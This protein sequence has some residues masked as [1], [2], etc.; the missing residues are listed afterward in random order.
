MDIQNKDKEERQQ[1]EHQQL[2]DQNTEHWFPI[3]Q[4]TVQEANT[5]I[6]TTRNAPQAFQ[7][8]KIIACA[9]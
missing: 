6:Q 2:Q 5:D 1:T 9:P 7:H 8:P 4:E 3:H